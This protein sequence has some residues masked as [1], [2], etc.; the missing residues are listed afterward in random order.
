M[1]ASGN[2]SGQISLSCLAQSRFKFEIEFKLE[3]QF[4]IQI[5]FGFPSGY[6][7]CLQFAGERDTLTSSIKSKRC[8]HL[9]TQAKKKWPKKYG[10][11][12]EKTVTMTLQEGA[13]FEALLPQYDCE[14]VSQLCKKIVRS[15][16]E[17]KLKTK[18][19]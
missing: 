16:V 7:T 9:E 14:N 3:K 12:Y 13:L 18:P 5:E 19:E 8:L 6:L 17:L 1:S 15:E 10:T 4:K 11:R 2:A